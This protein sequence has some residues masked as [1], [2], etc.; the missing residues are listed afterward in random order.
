MFLNR[1]LKKYLLKSELIAQRYYGLFYRYHC[2]RFS[3]CWSME[4]T[5]TTCSNLKDIFMTFR[6][7][8]DLW[9]NTLSARV[10]MGI[11]SSSG[12]SNQIVVPNEN[13]WKQPFRLRKLRRLWYL[14]ETIFNSITQVTVCEDS[15]ITLPPSSPICTRVILYFPSKTAM[16]TILNVFL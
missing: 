6:A 2:N 12:L 16:S 1:L 10:R 13:M 9:L 11:V 3:C 7:R 5:N 14:E 8:D 15:A 4:N